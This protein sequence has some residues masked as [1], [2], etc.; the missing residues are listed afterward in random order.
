MLWSPQHH[1]LTQLSHHHQLVFLYII[2]N[3][4]KMHLHGCPKQALFVVFGCDE[5]AINCQDPTRQ[6]TA[7]SVR[8]G[9][10]QIWI[11]IGLRFLRGTHL[12]FSLTLNA[13][14]MARV[15]R[16]ETSFHCVYV[17]GH[18]L[19]FVCSFRPTL[20]LF[21]EPRFCSILTPDL[22]SL[23]PRYIF[24]CTYYLLFCFKF[25]FI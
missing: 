16:R 6:A 5:A 7:S 22:I 8:A 10:G 3:E 20:H 14:H 4:R 25:L 2:L 9:P 21:L 11:G 13:F 1:Q 17:L 24:L 15:P 12:L 19:A 18:N 23:F